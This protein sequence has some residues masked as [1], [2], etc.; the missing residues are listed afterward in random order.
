MSYYFIGHFERSWEYKF[1]DPTIKSIFESKITQFFEDVEF[2][3]RD[4]IRD[5]VFKDEYIDIP[6]NIIDIDQDLISDFVQDL[7]YQDN[8][9]EPP[10]QEFVLE[11]RTLPP[12]ESMALRRSNKEKR[13][14]VPND[15]IVFWHCIST[16]TWG[17]QW[18]DKGWFDYFYQAMQ[19]SNFHK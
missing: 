2:A 18:S 19:S 6:I 10:I 15:Y 12:Q 5:F 16:R 7:T 14:A 8:V 3:G 13:N 17:R 1:Y 9:G 11:K 4:R